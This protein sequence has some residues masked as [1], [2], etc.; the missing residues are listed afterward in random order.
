MFPQCLQEK[1]GTGIIFH[2]N[3][4][5]IIHNCLTSQYHVVYARDVT[6]FNKLINKRYE[7]YSGLLGCEA[8]WKLQIMHT[9]FWM[10]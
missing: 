8:A 3:P 5:L 1:V 10:S 9:L 6:S 2:T 7:K 4:Q